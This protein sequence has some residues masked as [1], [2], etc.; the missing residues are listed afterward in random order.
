VFL[1]LSENVTAVAAH[2]YHEGVGEHPLPGIYKLTE[3]LIKEQLSA[4]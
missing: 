4:V 3:D 2:L 1:H